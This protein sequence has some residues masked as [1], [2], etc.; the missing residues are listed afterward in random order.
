MTNDRLFELMVQV[1]PSR[2]I[3]YL[4]DLAGVNVDDLSNDHA[5]AIRDAYSL[6]QA[7]LDARLG[8][9]LMQK[10][11]TAWN[12][13]VPPEYG[14]YSCEVLKRAAIEISLRGGEKH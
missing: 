8:N 1:N 10:I 14:L 3:A 12:D 5:L 11:T 6:F 9:V 4:L 2:N 7:V 13:A